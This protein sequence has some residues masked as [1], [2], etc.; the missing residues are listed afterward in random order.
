MSLFEQRRQG[1]PALRRKVATPIQHGHQQPRVPPRS[2]NGIYLHALASNLLAC[3]G[4]TLERCRVS[5]LGMRDD[6]PG[7]RQA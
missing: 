2:L 5:F 7:D 6:C 3:L 4:N 1:L